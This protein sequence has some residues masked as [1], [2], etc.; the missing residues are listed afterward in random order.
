MSSPKAER[1]EPITR[2]LDK[3]I[4]RSSGIRENSEQR[5]R[6]FPKTA[7]PSNI[8]L[9]TSRLLQIPAS[10]LATPSARPFGTIGTQNRTKIPAPAA[11]RGTGG[12]ESAIHGRAAKAR[13]GHERAGDDLPAMTSTR[14]M[15]I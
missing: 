8:L 7:P 11:P 10:Y 5:E 14:S 15:R 13:R 1:P 3:I 6:H 12:E 4:A 2:T 9:A